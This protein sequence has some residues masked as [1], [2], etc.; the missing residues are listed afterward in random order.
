MGQRLQMTVNRK[1]IDSIRQ[2]AGKRTNRAGNGYINVVSPATASEIRR[3]LGIT[4]TQTR[5]VLRAF[6]AAGV[7]I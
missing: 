4:A 7:E 3:T 1:R 2:R 6:R 5:N